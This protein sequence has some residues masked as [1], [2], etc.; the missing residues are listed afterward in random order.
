MVFNRS[1]TMS[2]GKSLNIVTKG[3]NTLRKILDILIL[4]FKIYLYINIIELNTFP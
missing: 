4:L 3:N 2:T 1:S